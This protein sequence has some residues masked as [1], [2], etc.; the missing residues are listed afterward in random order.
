MGAV[1]RTGVAIAAALVAVGGA[2]LL[3]RS[4]SAAPHYSVFHG[5]TSS[6]RSVTAVVRSAAGLH[7]SG[8]IQLGLIVLILTPIARVALSAVAF[9]LQ[10]D[11]L[12]VVLTLFVLAIL[13]LGLSG[14]AP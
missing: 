6:L 9:A 2:A 8:L 5:S 4:G 1:L 11:R 10:H 12:Y 13:L 3:A 7:P 14:T